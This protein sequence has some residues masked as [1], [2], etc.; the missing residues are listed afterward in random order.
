MKLRSLL[1]LA[2]KFTFLVC[3]GWQ[4]IQGFAQA[5]TPVRNIILVHGAWADGSSWAKVIPILEERGFH[6]TAVQNP[7]T[8]LADDVA[9]T[10]RAIDQADGP[11]LLVGHSYGG[12][13]ISQAGND[14]KVAGLV[15]VAAY[16]PEI[17]ESSFTTTS[18][19]TPTPI[20]AEI[21]AM[22]DDPNLLYLTRKGVVEDF[23][24]DLTHIERIN[25]D[26]TQGPTAKTALAAPA[27]AA[28]WHSK[29]SWY[30][31]AMEDRT[32]NPE[33]ER[34]A[35][36]RMGAK[37]LFLPTS[38]VAMLAMPREVAVFI[39]DAAIKGKGEK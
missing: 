7:L 8:S 21:R 37:I 17:G 6:V 29:P 31:V 4:T 34:Y 23:C 35:A 9:A 3:F 22:K 28:A 27:T 10:K 1:T 24:Q 19:F 13:V 39:E 32:I 11:V 18:G 38:H 16:A 33:Y 30:V 26:V 12:A 36:R 2:C 5:K 20:G 25:L 14:P 15:Y